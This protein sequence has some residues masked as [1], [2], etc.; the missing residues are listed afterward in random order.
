MNF[1]I[2]VCFI[3]KM[4]MNLI[5]PCISCVVDPLPNKFPYALVSVVGKFVM[6]LG[7][8]SSVGK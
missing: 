4:F 2:F 7:K 5:M 1:T 3:R 6:F 8:A